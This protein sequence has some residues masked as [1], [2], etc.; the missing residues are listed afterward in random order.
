MM[1]RLH[2]GTNLTSMKSHNRSLVLRVLNSME[3][4]SRSE[5]ARVTGLT[6][7]SITNIIHELME[8]GIIYETGTQA[9]DS[10]RKPVLLKLSDHALY[11]VGLYISRDFAYAN[12]VNLKGEILQEA[13][14]AFDLTENLPAFMELVFSL[15]A[16]VLPENESE[17]KRILGIG[18]ASIGP[19]DVIN[20]IILDPPNFRGLRRIPV[21]EELGKK[22][23]LPAFLDNDMNASAIAEKIFG[24]AKKTD[25][26]V[27]VGVTNG[28]GAGIVLNGEI[29]RGSGGSAG[30]IGH[31]TV[32]VHGEKCACGNSGCLE[33]Y[34]SI[35]AV[36][37][38][39]KTS[40]EFGADSPLAKKQ[41]VTWNDI[42]DAAQSGDPISRKAIDRLCY[43]LS[44]G[45][46]NVV[47]TF[48][49]QKIYL[50]HD[51]AR[52]GDL[53]LAPLNELVDR[54]RLL[55]Q[56]KTSIIELSAFGEY[57]PCI[58][59]PAIIW[60]RFFHGDI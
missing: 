13:R 1:R 60:N 15:I 20:G 7:T 28:I 32:D 23:D 24:Y 33:L 19:A 49:P 40:L 12:L 38:Q 46:I 18:I 29:Y 11:A 26:F 34:V 45:L 56:G 59:A 10:G 50:G 14:Q 6:K 16:R 21:V 44:I 39:V 48:D 41:S 43:N 3:Q 36:V 58:G 8:E 31:T 5:L 51:I 4:I 27:Y 52:A 57:A 55:R 53:V 17:R 22:F 54:N 37:S 30:E 35:P 2:N 47:N 42:V 25:H 9:S